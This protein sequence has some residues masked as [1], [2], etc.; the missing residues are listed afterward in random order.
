MKNKKK[1][2]LLSSLCRE[3][4]VVNDFTPQ[5]FSNEMYK[6]AKLELHESKDEQIIDII[7]KTSYLNVRVNLYDQIAAHWNLSAGKIIGGLK[8]I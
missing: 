1:Y 6:D 3:S 8:I 5:T 2:P 4:H 7:W